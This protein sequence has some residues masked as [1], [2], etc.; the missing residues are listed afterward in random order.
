[1]GSPGGPGGT[2]LRLFS[3]HGLAPPRVAATCESFTEVAALIAGTDWLALLPRDI[4]EH[5]LLGPRVAPIAIR[6][7]PHRFDTHLVMRVDPPPT[8]AAERF[9]AMCR[10][11]AR[12]AGGA[13]G[14]ETREEGG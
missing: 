5:G 12:V 11:W 9:A 14:S 4:P 13:A 3:D 8:P 10:S 6:E 2:V 1:M 7:R